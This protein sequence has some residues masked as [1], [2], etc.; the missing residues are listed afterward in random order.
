MK[1]KAGL[2]PLAFSQLAPISGEDS[3]FYEDFANGVEKMEVG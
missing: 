1:L 2:I 3:R